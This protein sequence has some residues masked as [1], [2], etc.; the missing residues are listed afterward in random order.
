MVPTQPAQRPLGLK[1]TE[2]SP[3]TKTSDSHRSAQVGLPARRA[4]IKALHRILS[5]KTP[6]D[7]A[8]DS[9]AMSALNA[10]D[11]ALARAIVSTSLR[12]KGQLDA[13]LDEFI[14]KPLNRKRTGLAYEAMLAGAAQI[15]FMR[16]PAHA[17]I[18][19]AARTLSHDLTG[20]RKLVGFLNAVLRN[21]ERHGA[22]IMESQDAARLN[23]PGW[24]FES[25]TKAY[26]SEG[27]KL[28]AEAHLNEA[29]LDV[30]V[31]DDAEGWAKKLKGSALATGSV[32]LHENPGRIELLDGYG[33][34]AWWV[35][36]AAAALPAQLLGDVAGKRVIDLCAAPGGKTAQSASRGAE[37]TAVDISAQRLE[38]LQENLERLGLKAETVCC[39]VHDFAPDEP[40]D[41]VLLDAPCSAT[42]TIRRHPDVP[43]L[44]T[45]GSVKFLAPLQA[46]L[47]TKAADLVKP[48]GLVIYCTCSLQPEEG[49]RQ[50]AKALKSGV[51]ERVPVKPEEIGGLS[52]AITADG[53]VRTLPSMS[54]GADGG[55][56][57][58]FISRLRRV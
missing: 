36:D 57:G 45:K 37:V 43:Y 41:M 24:L 5:D 2:S 14:A 54:P 26:G 4:A 31:K 52:E 38:R 56:D 13:I 22:E 10:R 16:V 6:L 35:Q 21:V 48:G 1:P 15:I 28:I 33:D 29:P 9:A 30:S 8:L 19:L 44:K 50:I 7:P 46:A 27:A 3:V 32:R 25:W 55:M 51:Y 20:G 39:D 40:A 58:F 47:L 42:D 17:A 53:D 11:R 12:R 34:G 18:D 49:E 23:T